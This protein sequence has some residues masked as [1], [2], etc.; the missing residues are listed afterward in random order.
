MSYLLINPHMPIEMKKSLK[1]FD[2]PIVEVHP[3]DHLP[4][5]LSGHPDLLVHPLPDGSVIVDPRYYSYYSEQLSDRNIYPGWQEIG[6]KYPQDTIFNGFAID[7]LFVHQIENTDPQVLD[8]YKSCH[9]ELISVKQGYSRCNTL[10]GQ[11]YIMTSD[12]SI[13]KALK[14]KIKTYSIHHKH[15]DLPGYSYGFIGGCSGRIGRRLILS[16]HFD[17][18]PSS[19]KMDAVFKEEK[20][21]IYYLWEKNL[22]DIGSIFYLE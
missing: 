15:I 7:G 18:H 16:G 19:K 2:I 20:E 13:L 12:P 5:P 10:L 8:Y 14:D 4:Y 21:E 3:N 9:Y 6:N 22:L 17:D 1:N 11:D